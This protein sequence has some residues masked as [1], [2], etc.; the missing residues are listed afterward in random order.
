MAAP[1]V[2]NLSDIIAQYTAAQQPQQAQL[3]TEVASN[4]ASGSAQTAGL[5]TAKT[6]AF[7]DIEQA[8]NNKGMYFSGFSPDA[9]AKYTGSTYLPA[10]A[11]LQST[12]SATRDTLLGKKA[13]L[14]AAASTSALSTQQ[15]EQKTLDAYNAQQEQ[16]AATARAAAAQQAFEAS[17]NAKNRAASAATSAAK[18]LTAAQ[19][20]QAD[21]ST[22]GQALSGVRGRDGY[23]SPQSWASGLNKWV[24][25]GYSTADYVNYF[26]GLANPADPQDYGLPAK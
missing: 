15:D 10:L 1:T 20:K 24:Q 14:S 17:E 9:E 3:D 4:D 5:N 19:Q 13:D 23:I 8:A 2:Q 6:N 26:K 12:I 16:E 11:K 7:G 22:L 18:P 21:A 25:A